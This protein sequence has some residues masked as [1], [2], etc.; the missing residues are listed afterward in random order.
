MAMMSLYFI[1]KLKP[2]KFIRTQNS[3]LRQLFIQ[4]L[5]YND[6]K[7]R[8]I[9]QPS[10]YLGLGRHLLRQPKLSLAQ[11]PPY[12]VQDIKNKILNYN[13]KHL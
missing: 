2:D 10:K 5:N 3:E 1:I 9:G 11:M 12:G 4:P 6:F 7:S 13:I 8:Y